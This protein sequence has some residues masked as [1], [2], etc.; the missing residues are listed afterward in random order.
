MTVVG[1]REIRFYA[2]NERPYGALSNLYRRPVR[3]MGRTF[4]TSEHAYQF[5]KARKPVVRDWLM[6]APS[7]S[8]LA[9]AAHG[10][11]RWDVASDWSRVKLTRMRL[12]LACKFWQ[13]PDLRELLIGTGDAPLVEYTTVDNPTNRFWGEVEGRGGKNEMGQA[14]MY[15]RADLVAGTY[16]E[17][18]MFGLAEGIEPDGS[19]AAWYCGGAS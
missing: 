16:C 15:V 8:L 17:E 7:P 6:V 2:A 14:L 10:L 5:G 4:P 13:H 18:S 3:F 19:R 9:M 11:Y 1:T 12:V